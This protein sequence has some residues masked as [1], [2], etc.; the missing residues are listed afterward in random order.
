MQKYNVAI[1]MSVYKLDKCR[2]V[3]LAIDSLLNQTY[4]NIHIFIEVDGL[5]SKSLKDLLS[6]YKEKDNISLNFNSQCKGLATRLNSI[7]D[8]VII[9][10]KYDFIARMDADDISSPERIE[11][12]LLFLLKNSEISVVGSDMIEIS[13]LGVEL[14]YKK[15]SATHDELLANIIKRCPLNHPSVMFR[16]DVFTSPNLRY[17]SELMNTQDYYLWID[18]LAAGKK[19]ANINQPLLYFRVNDQFH[20]RRGFK[21]A[22]NDF[23]SRIYAFRHLKVLS[24]G[25]LVHTVL[26]FLLRI[27]P[28]SIKVKA[29]SYFR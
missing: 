24:V 27:A 12:Q 4:K 16:A 15:M 7:I 28:K 1:A 11:T 18:L 21:K 5:V 8:K 19:F 14:F 2:Y 26:L 9:A 6:T 23:K 13:E 20:S 29:Y 10:D 3:K 22:V 17:K 25:N